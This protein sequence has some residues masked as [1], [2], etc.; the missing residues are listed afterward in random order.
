MGS[1]PEEENSEADLNKTEFEEEKVKYKGIRK[2]RSGKFV[3]EIGDPKKRGN[4]RLG[5]FL[6][7][8]EVAK[9]YDK[10]AFKMRGTKANLNFPLD[11]GISPEDSTKTKNG[12]VG[13]KR[14]KDVSEAEAKDDGWLRFAEEGKYGG[15]AGFVYT[16]R[17]V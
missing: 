1:T 7:P 2:R 12:I 17:E 5:T 8:I 15:G 10:A 3:A 4:V 13:R 11:F 6:S 16:E 9:A 14:T